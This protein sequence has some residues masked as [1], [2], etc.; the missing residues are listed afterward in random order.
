MFIALMKSVTILLVLA[1][2]PLAQAGTILQY[3]HVSDQ[4]PAATSVTPDQFAH[5]LAMLADSGMTVVRLDALLDAARAGDDTRD[6]VAITFDDGYANLATHAM[7]LL[8]E[9]G[10]PAAVFVTTSQVGGSEMLTL[11]QLSEMQRAGHLVLNHGREHA[12]VVRA[13]PGESLRQRRE[14]IRQDILAAQR[15]LEG[16]L[17]ESVPRILA[18]PYGEHD[19]VTRELA[20]KEGFVALAQVSGALGPDTDWQA[21]PRI[22]VNRRYAEWAPL[23]DKLRALPLPVT[24]MSPVDGLTASPRPALELR[25]RVPPASLNCFVDGMPAEPQLKSSDDDGSW[26]IVVQSQ[27]RLAPGR[28]RVTCTRAVNGGRFQWFSWLWMVRDGA[29]WYPEY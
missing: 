1:I 3:H 6:Q 22:A 20:R 14:R 24:V 5:H 4:T 11:E 16:H 2:A 23:R 25:V 27:E 21:V 29:D 8:A 15:W 19:A 10:W 13:L 26:T 28:H 18:W 12:H 17:P 7:P 9:R